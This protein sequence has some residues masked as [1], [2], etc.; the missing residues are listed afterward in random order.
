MKLKIFLIQGLVSLILI[1]LAGCDTI[2]REQEREMNHT[3]VH[4]MAG[5]VLD[6]PGLQSRVNMCPGYL[7]VERSG[8]GIPMVGKRGKGVL[9]NSKTGERV[10]VKVTEVE[11][12][13]AWGVGDYTGLYLFQSLE[14]FQ[15]AFTNTWQAETGSIYVK[16]DRER[17]VESAEADFNPTALVVRFFSGTIGRERTT[18]NKKSGRH[19]NDQRSYGQHHVRRDGFIVEDNDFPSHSNEGNEQYNFHMNF[20][21]A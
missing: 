19:R 16:V 18:H 6:I 7:V 1:S 14:D 10:S 15:Q 13:G 3:A 9:T 12:D 2:G 20:V 17:A 4:A 5:M 21:A 8:S 11:V